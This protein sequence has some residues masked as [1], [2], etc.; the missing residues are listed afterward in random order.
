MGFAKFMAGT[1]GRALRVIAGI[2]II[3]AGLLAID[4]TAGYIVAVIG[5]VPVL[6]GALDFCLLAPLLGA[7]FK[8][9]AVRNS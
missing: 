7:P 4:G 9:E 2:A 1:T 6:A 3:A 8:G 5:V